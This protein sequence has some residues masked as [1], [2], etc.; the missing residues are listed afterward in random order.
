MIRHGD[1]NKILSHDVE[2]SLSVGLTEKG[3]TDAEDFGRSIPF[4]STIRIFHSPAVRCRETAQM[5]SRGARSQGLTVELIQEEWNLCAPY[6]KDD[7]CLK[8]ADRLGM[9]FFR[10]WMSGQISSDWVDG[11]ESSAY[12]VVE[13][14]LSRLKEK[15]DCLDVHVS[16]DWDIML[17]REFILGIKHEDA[18]WLSCLDGISFFQKD[19]GYRA[20]Y[21]ERCAPIKINDGCKS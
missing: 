5:I 13:P 10:T 9:D 2:G 7:R 4:F 3:F 14:I 1:R 19:G 12:M 18:G 15:E 20:C 21:R 6:V 11:A 8:E 16:H 17:L